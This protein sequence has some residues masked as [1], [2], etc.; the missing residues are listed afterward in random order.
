M[1]RME[2]GNGGRMFALEIG[3]DAEGKFMWRV[4]SIRNGEDS[5]E[6]LGSGVEETED[7][8]LNA[9]DEW[10]TGPMIEA[11]NSAAFRASIMLG[12]EDERDFA[13][14]REGK[15]I[16]TKLALPTMDDV[17]KHG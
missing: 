1:K 8:A 5:E 12:I 11:L 14:Q 4:N 3:E 17:I 6:P 7:A 9:A 2:F 16:V 10:I 13:L 15:S